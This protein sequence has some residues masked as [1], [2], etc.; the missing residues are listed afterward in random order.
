VRRLYQLARRRVAEP[1]LDDATVAQQL[2][3]LMLDRVRRRVQV[4]RG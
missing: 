2:S 3:P 1:D 4:Q